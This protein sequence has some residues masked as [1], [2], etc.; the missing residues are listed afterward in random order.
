MYVA[1]SQRKGKNMSEKSKIPQNGK[2]TNVT[3]QQKAY[4]IVMAGIAIACLVGFVILK[5]V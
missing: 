3:K 1:I 4:R 5:L 2:E